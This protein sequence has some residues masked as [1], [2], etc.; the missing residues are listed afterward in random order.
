MYKV[1]KY[2]L[3]FIVFTT[4]FSVSNAQNPERK[5]KKARKSLKEAKQDLL[6]AD[7]LLLIAQVDSIVE[8]DKALKSKGDKKQKETQRNK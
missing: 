7:E 4:L 2:S 6:I 1:L 8:L 5:L 3:L